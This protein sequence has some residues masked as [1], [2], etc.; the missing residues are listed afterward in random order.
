MTLK[1]LCVLRDVFVNEQNELIWKDLRTHTVQQ[2]HYEAVIDFYNEMTAQ[3]LGPS[4]LNLTRTEMAILFAALFA[5]IKGDS[6]NESKLQ[7]CK[8]DA[9]SI[10]PMINLTHNMEYITRNYKE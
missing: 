5:E 3:W 7:V 4:F 1:D 8:K 2:R 9:L 10:L 6:N